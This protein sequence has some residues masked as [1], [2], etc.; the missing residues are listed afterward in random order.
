[1]FSP[2]RFPQVHVC[3]DEAIPQTFFHLKYVGDDPYPYGRSNGLVVESLWPMKSFEKRLFFFDFW[4]GVRIRI[5]L[6]FRRS[7]LLLGEGDLHLFLYMCR[8][9]MACAFLN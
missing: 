6:S 3:I 2:S 9:A 1:M 4:L 8:S 7:F 5:L